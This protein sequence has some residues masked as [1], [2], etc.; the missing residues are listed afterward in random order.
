MTEQVRVLMIAMQIQTHP[1][2]L[3]VLS[4]V[5]FHNQHFEWSFYSQVYPFLPTCLLP[6]LY[7]STPEWTFSY[8][9]FKSYTQI[10][11]TGSHGLFVFLG[12]VPG[13]PNHSTRSRV[14]GRCNKGYINQEYSVSLA[15]LYKL[16]ILHEFVNL[17]L[18]K[19]LY[20]IFPMEINKSKIMNVI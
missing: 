1:K 10:R 6:C 2:F 13:T 14:R 12:G 4:T 17:S 15:F 20:I 16:V 18:E 5:L 19:N 8:P 9:F 11:T 7:L 3:P